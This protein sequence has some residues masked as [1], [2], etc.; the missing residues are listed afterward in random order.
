MT[1]RTVRNFSTDRLFS[2]GMI[3]AGMFVALLIF[4]PLLSLLIYA[5]PAR[6]LE[7]L[8]NP[9][10]IS[11]LQVTLKSSLLAT[12]CIFITGLPTAFASSRFSEK[13]RATI[14]TLL[15]L[16][17]VLPQL[18]AGLA[19]LLAFGRNGIFGRF[20]Y[21]W[22]VQIPFS[23]VA[24]VMAIIFVLAPF[25]IRRATVLFD[26]VDRELEEAAQLLGGRAFFTFCHVTLPLCRRPLLAEA[27]MVFLQSIGLF[28]AIILFAGNI[29]GRT[30]TLTLAIFDAFENNPEVA[31]ALAALLLLI[32][33]LLLLVGRLLLRN[34]GSHE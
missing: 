5:D 12:L 26:Q 13:S 21:P 15:E 11:A 29:P 8:T 1:G 25:F 34:I 19:L 17:M 9:A 4:L 6:Q 20:F 27:I 23:M 31:F 22:G 32:S 18:V 2:L 28:G 33:A 16:P 3:L 24:V 10:I 7:L 14:D 30:R